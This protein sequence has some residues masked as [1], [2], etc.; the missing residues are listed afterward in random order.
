[1][2]S[3]ISIWVLFSTAAAFPGESMNVAVC[4]V[5]HI[6]DAV[7]EH[8]ET[9]TAYVFRSMDVEIHWTDC[10]AVGAEDARMRPDFI[11]RVRVGG[12]FTKAGPLSLEAMGRAFLD[13]ADDGF[14]A[15][16]YYGAIHELALLCPI[17]EG[18]QLL[19]YT[20]AHE[21]GHLLIGRGHRPNGIMRAAW[22]KPELEALKQRRLKFN[23]AERAAILSKLRMRVSSGSPMP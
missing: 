21:L 5:G 11:V 9:E 15:D 7:I 20:I 4:N 1:M 6:P 18:D 14:M 16:T 19:G 3:A 23:Q 2:R 17:A 22:G 13:S 8:A 12:H 10:G